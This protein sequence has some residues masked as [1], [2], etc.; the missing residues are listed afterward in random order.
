LDEQGQGVAG[1]KG[2]R[3][4][5][6]HR[7][8]TISRLA[9]ARIGAASG[10]LNACRPDRRDHSS[11]SPNGARWGHYTGRGGSILVLW[12]GLAAG[13]R[14]LLGLGSSLAKAFAGT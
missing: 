11:G 10:G 4:D 7:R 3:G 5:S 9:V 8:S 13:G 6:F 12:R 2:Y 14:L 1:G